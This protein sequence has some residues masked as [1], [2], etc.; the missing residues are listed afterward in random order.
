[1]IKKYKLPTIIGI[2]VLIFGI[3][4]GVFLINSRQVFKLGANID[5]IPKNVRFTNITNSSF[6]VTW[7]TDI[8]STGFVKWGTSELTLSKVALGEG[9]G[10]NFVHSATIMGINP[11][12]K[13]YLK[14]NSNSN[15]YD[16]N[17]IPWQETTENIVTTSDQNL[18]ASGN[19]LKPDA[20]TPAV[21]IVYLTINGIVLSAISSQGGSYVIPISTYISNLPDTTPIE[22]SVQGGQNSLAQAVIYPKYIKSVPTIVLGRTYDF[23][24]LQEDMSGNLPESNL[25]VP[26]SVEVSSRFE[27]TKSET[28]KTVDNVLVES[29]EEGEIITT[30]NPEFFGSGPKNTEIEVIVES[31]M[32][33]QTIT[34]SSNGSWKWSPPNDLAPGEHKLTVK[35][36]DASGI[37]RTITRTFVVSA[38]EGPAFEATP[39]ASLSPSPTSTAIATTV[40]SPTASSSSTP[41]SATPTA[42]LPPTPETGSLTATIG[43]FIMGI[44]ILLSSIFIWNKQYAQ[45]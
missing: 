9:I 6:T 14:I 10:K 44:G 18:I 36:R 38:A 11:N 15:D 29:I 1:M 16:N 19:I 34:V 7:T 20:S 13:I 45:G 27:V 22:I 41:I 26:E 35:W 23:R 17:G 24:T 37:L 32:Q 25:T 43:L 5:A 42:T 30:V 4:A 31:E 21:S 12:T 39:S 8:E 2:V 3:I 40:A 33:S 28:T